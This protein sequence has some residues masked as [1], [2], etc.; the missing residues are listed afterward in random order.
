M[1]NSNLDSGISVTG[2]TVTGNGDE[3][4][5]VVTSNSTITG[6]A[7]SNNT[8]DGGN[9]GISWNSDSG[10]VDVNITGNTV[11]GSTDNGILV[12][13]T[14][15]AIG[16]DVHI[17]FNTVNGDGISPQNGIQLNLSNNAQ[18][19]TGTINGNAASDAANW[20]VLVN[21]GDNALV[22]SLTVDAN[23]MSNN[24]IDGFLYT[25]SG[26]PR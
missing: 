12:T 16:N 4:I 19:L 13:L 23:I 5:V 22:D 9:N 17:D 25:A 3:P 8:V 6:G 24:G 10:T 2:M 20:G 26:P 1:N 18:L 21:V 7:I 11:T 15:T 14:G